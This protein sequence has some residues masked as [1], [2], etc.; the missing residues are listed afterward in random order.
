MVRL[1]Y[2]SLFDGGIDAAVVDPEL[3]IQLLLPLSPWATLQSFP[4]PVN[5]TDL[6]NLFSFKKIVVNIML[7]F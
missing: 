4:L 3:S 5:L 1:V 2:D 6:S 7:L